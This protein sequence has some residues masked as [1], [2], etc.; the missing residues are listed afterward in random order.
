MSKLT[1]LQATAPRR[2]FLQIDDHE[3]GHDEPFPKDTEG[4]T[5][6]AEP[7]Q[8]CEVAYVREDLA[9]APAGEAEPVAWMYTLWFG[10]EAGRQVAFCYRFDLAVASP[11]GREGIDFAAGGKVE[12]QPLYAAPIAQPQPAGLSPL[13]ESKYT[14]NGHAIVNRASGEEIPADEPVFIFRA[15]DKWA[16]GVLGDYATLVEDPA[17][18]AAVE[19]RFIQFGEWAEAHPER[20]KEPDTQPSQPTL[21]NGLTEQ[22][23]AASASV[24]GLSGAQPEAPAEPSGNSVCPACNGEGSVQAMTSHL[25]PDDYEYDESCVACNGTGSP[26]LKD[27]LEGVGFIRHPQF[28]ARTYIS[29]EAVM[30]IVEARAALATPAPAAQQPAELTDE[31]YLQDTRIY[32][33]NDVSWWAK[34]GNGYTTDISKAHVYTREEAFRQ[35]AMRGCDRAW[36]KT[37]IDGKTRPAVDMQHIDHEEAIKAQGGSQ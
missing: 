29:R 36:P 24:A 10:D 27:A 16:A 25:G 12:E 1:P 34:D 35:A 9:A 11:F 2:I 13:Q 14:V 3:G 8:A 26:D 18:K 19:E 22:E 30:K 21:L 4:V 17:H 32:V 20:M 31:W 6:C 37:Y 5:W 23:T 7:A 33:G 15:R 28:P